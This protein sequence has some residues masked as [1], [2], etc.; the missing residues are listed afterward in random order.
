M[1]TIFHDP[2]TASWHT[3]LRQGNSE[4][5]Q[6]ENINLEFLP[7][8]SANH[9]HNIITTRMK[10]ILLWMAIPLKTTSFLAPQLLV[11][12]PS[13]F[14]SLVTLETTQVTHYHQQ[15]ININFSNT[16][17]ISLRCLHRIQWGKFI[18]HA[19]CIRDF[20]T[21]TKRHNMAD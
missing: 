11:L 21:Q 10:I 2:E 15:L 19:D 6:F 3:E 18:T 12:S 20:Q 17:R 8:L 14:I 13:L 9:C 16:R 1:I 4:P 7:I 5:C